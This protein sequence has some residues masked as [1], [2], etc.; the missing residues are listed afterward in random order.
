M[1]SVPSLGNQDPVCYTVWPKKWKNEFPSFS[2][3]CLQV[4]FVHLPV[5]YLMPPATPGDSIWWQLGIPGHWRVSSW[6]M[7]HSQ[8]WI[9]DWHFIAVLIW[10]EFLQSLCPRYQICLPPCILQTRWITTHIGILKRLWKLKQCEGK[11]VCFTEG[12]ILLMAQCNLFIALWSCVL[13]GVSEI[14]EI[15]LYHSSHWSLTL[16]R[17]QLHNRSRA[18]LL[19]F[20]QQVL[21][22]ITFLWL[23]LTEVLRLEFSWEGMPASLESLAYAFWISKGGGIT[24]NLFTIKVYT[25]IAQF[26]PLRVSFPFC[27]FSSWHLQKDLVFVG[28][29]REP[30]W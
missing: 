28:S 14:C 15:A 3:P 8:L 5:I 22:E 21:W 17:H 29:H 12:E 11:T 30:T 1:G 18:P 16:C 23:E 20:L 9:H 4:L 27:P 7:N 25:L 6:L 10:S 2:T 19:S 24:N 13:W 26:L